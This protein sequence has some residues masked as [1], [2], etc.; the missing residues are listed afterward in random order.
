M[1]V[2]L[3]KQDDPL[4]YDVV[5]ENTGE[6]L[7]SNDVLRWIAWGGTTAIPHCSLAIVD[8]HSLGDYTAILLSLLSF[9]CAALG[10]CSPA[11]PHSS[12]RSH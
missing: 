4:R 2:E 8:Y 12:W 10:R 3:A 6:V 11:S 1:Q 7:H 5:F 9:S